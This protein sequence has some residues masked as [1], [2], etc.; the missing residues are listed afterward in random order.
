MPQTPDSDDPRTLAEQAMDRFVWEPG[1]S[2]RVTRAA[3]TME[4]AMRS[5]GE[6][7]SVAERQ[8]LRAGAAMA[9]HLADRA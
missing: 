8:A 6:S 4:T 1:F 2:G 3:V 5:A 9:L 7:L